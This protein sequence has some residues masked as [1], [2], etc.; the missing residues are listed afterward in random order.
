MRP[1]IAIMTD[2]GTRDPFV[3][4]MKGVMR[5]FCPNAEFIDVTHEIE[6]QNLRQAAF[7]VLTSW[8]WFPPGT[9]FLTV[10]DPGVG[11]E[12]RPLVVSAG[13]CRF[14]APDNGLLS[15]I[16]AETPPDKLI[17][18]ENSDRYLKVVSDTF[19]GRD[20][21]APLAAHLACGLDPMQMGS[22]TSTIQQL[23]APRLEVHSDRICAEILHTDRFG[24]LVT[25]IGDCRWGQ[26]ETILLSPRFG[27]GAARKLRSEDLRTSVGG[28]EI[29]GVHKTYSSRAEGETLACI[30]SSGFLELG[31]NQGNAAR[32]LETRVGDAVTVSWKCSNS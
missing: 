15:W 7:S 1:I 26:D 16:L 2:F 17:S 11:S 8:R 22:E 9:V 6:P 4:V 25:S 23:P 18:A 21:F 5:R 19:H 32:L 3:A 28:R 24:N 31:V 14:V 20:V 30:G 13:G 10:V 12:R 27:G 29:R